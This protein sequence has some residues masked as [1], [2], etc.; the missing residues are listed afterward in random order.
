[1]AFVAGRAVARLARG[2]LCGSRGFSSSVPAA[3]RVALASCTVVCAPA[4]VSAR[5]CV[6]R[7]AGEAMVG[8]VS[9]RVLL[10]V[11]WAAQLGRLTGV[12]EDDEDL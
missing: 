1:M 9:R 12:G 4:A 3:S 5:P 7:V 2:G 11:A 8:C 10:E 6:A